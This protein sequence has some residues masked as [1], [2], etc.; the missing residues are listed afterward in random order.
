MAAAALANKL[1]DTYVVLLAERNQSVRRKRLSDAGKRGM[2]RRWNRERM[3][4]DHMH[5]PERIARE[6]RHLFARHLEL[7]DLVAAGNIG[8]V[9]AANSYHPSRGDFAAFA[10]FRVRGAIID[11]Q[12]RRTYREERN[13]SLNA[14]ADRHAGWL[15][16]SM[17]T[18]SRPRVDAILTS[19]A[20]DPV[21]TWAISGLT[22]RH[23]DVFAAHAAGVAPR[24]I[25]EALGLSLSSTRTVLREARV[26]VANRLRSRGIER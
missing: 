16:P 18:C 7:Q 19:A 15:P 10:Y 14:I 24:A 3:I 4:L 8:L 12:K 20:V 26:F 6:V 1:W 25:S 5:L 2:W 11:S 17:D 23:A 9:A 13:E 21:I 22:G